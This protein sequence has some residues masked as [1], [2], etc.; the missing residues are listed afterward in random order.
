MV[1]ADER[2]SWTLRLVTAALLAGHAGCTLMEAH[3]SFAHNAA[4]V[5]PH[6]SASVIP[7]V[8][9]FELCLAAGVL[10]RPSV[11]LLIGVGAWKL[12]TECLFLFAGS[13]V[14][15][16]VERFGSYT[17]PLALALLLIER[18]QAHDSLLA[19]PSSLV[20]NP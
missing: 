10:L 8:G 2:L 13:P 5:W 7:G 16:V 12:A 9:A 6:A 11:P 19:P 3:G 17:A 14:W 1:D 4:A 18:Q 20:P 15:E